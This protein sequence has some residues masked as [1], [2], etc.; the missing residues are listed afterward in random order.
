MLQLLSKIKIHPLF[1]LTIVIGLFTAHVKELV[2]L[3]LIVFIHEMGHAVAAHYFGWRI[4]KIELLPFGGVAV[5][6]EHGNKPLREEVIVLLAGPVQH[7]WMMVLCYGLFQAKM[8]ESGLYEF[9]MWNNI[10][11]LLFNLIP[12]WPLDG[13]KLMFC[14][15]STRYPFRLA[16]YYTLVFS[17][18]ICVIMLVIATFI[19]PYNLT[20][21]VV[22]V[23]LFFSIWVEWRQRTFVFL[24]FLLDRYY[25]DREQ[26]TK[27][28]PIRV[29]GSEPLYQVFWKF[30][31]GYKHPIAVQQKYG[32]HMLD[33][34]ELLYAYFAQKKTASSIQE[35]IS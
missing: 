11:L 23:F 2:F 16:H 21:W 28:K 25:G 29:T 17:F 22:L 10:T 7:V 34:N 13:G 19:I 14:F 9:L 18:S 27:L 15:L 6:E 32:E 24:R 3:F 31:R 26:V 1:W 5:M 30:Q 4:R 33:E 35:L 20:M 8:M 12:V